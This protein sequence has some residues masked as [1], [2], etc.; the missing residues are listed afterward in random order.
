[1]PD[2]LS[3]I[4]LIVLAGIGAQWAAWRFRVPSILLLLLSGIAL[5]P[6]STLLTGD[7][8]PV[9]DTRT[10]FGDGLLTL[11]SLS[12]GLILYE[13]GLT[14]DLREVA[15][16]RRSVFSLVTLGALVTWV[17]SSALAVPVLGL[18]IEIAAL[19][20]AILVV[21]GPTVV[22]PLL[23]H[24]RPKGRVGAILKWEGIVIDPIGATLAVLV[25]EAVA[26]GVVAGDT[27]HAVVQV[28][29][30]LLLTIVVG[31]FLGWLCAWLLAE[32][33]RRYWIPD[34]LQ[35]PVSLMLVILAFSLSNA[36][37][38]EAGLLATTVMGVVLA[39]QRKARIHHIVEFKENLRVLLISILFIVLGANL[40]LEELRA[41]RAG[42]L[43]FVALL[44]LIVRP[45]SVYAATRGDTLTREE[46]LFM[47]WMAP[48]GIVAAAVASVFALRLGELEGFTH[49][50]QAR[51]LVPIMFTV[52]IGTVVVY[53]LSASR[54]ARG[55]GVADQDPQ[56]VLIIGA[57]KWARALASLLA[58]R[59]IPVM[60]VD[61]NRLN[62]REARMAGLRV[63]L[64]NVLE[65]GVAEELDLTGIGRVL[66]LTP[67]D[68]VNALALQQFL[69]RFERAELYRLPMTSKEGE[70]SSHEG[71]P[72]FAKGMTYAQ[73][74][75][76]F[77]AGHV[78][79]ATRLTDEF[80][81]ASYRLL[82]G[83]GVPLF[84]IS[85]EGRLTI[86]TA[87]RGLSQASAGTTIISLVDPE[88]LLMGDLD[89][90]P[91][92]PDASPPETRTA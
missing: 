42:E 49:A 6:L 57:H 81:L 43:I 84:T 52:I 48:R 41:I 35:N 69:G 55:L 66:A 51:R 75:S 85:P 90:T 31:G 47:C 80:P 27:G 38:H 34:S 63:R 62:L 78:L 33:I 87:D 89:Q 82:Y 79:K 76:R 46:R 26:I 53:G 60:L 67:N 54:V 4:T 7:D 86:I 39:N 1:M 50:D 9:L 15:G 10:L 23:R 30:G 44:I 91:D 24:V 32:L 74:A 5:G 29:K 28:C 64:A 88:A 17:L 70:V 83:A 14:L 92:D 20:G 45:L 8:R 77:G 18:P 61:T 40:Q 68:E 72:L 56:G 21:T 2:M 3:A 71:R 22:G 59:S 25:F 58:Q 11:V 73:I 16:S 13:G 37:Q 19:I 36:V 12:V 65:E